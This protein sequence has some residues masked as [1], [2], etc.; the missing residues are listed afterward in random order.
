MHTR[1]PCTWVLWVLSSRCRA[2]GAVRSRLWICIRYWWCGWRAG[3]GRG[4]AH[5]HCGFGSFGIWGCLWACA[6]AVRWGVWILM[7]KLVSCAW[8]LW[9]LSSC[10]RGVGAV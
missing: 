5:P 9:I 4:C 3:V 10:G 2:V 7:S 6:W 1:S 8:V